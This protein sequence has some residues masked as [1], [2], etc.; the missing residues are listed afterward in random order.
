MT[1][2]ELIQEASIFFLD[3]VHKIQAGQF[4]ELTISQDVVVIVLEWR[5]T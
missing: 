2:R 3:I 1:I 4:L 5:R